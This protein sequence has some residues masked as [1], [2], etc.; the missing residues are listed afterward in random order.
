M[1]SF[2]PLEG[3]DYITRKYDIVD[4]L[5]D[6]EPEIIT[7]DPNAEEVKDEYRLDNCPFI[8]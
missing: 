6:N 3:N 4:D 2:Q 1:D 5:I 7:A 8:Y